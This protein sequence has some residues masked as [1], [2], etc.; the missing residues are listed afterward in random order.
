MDLN[1]T[2][3]AGRLADKPTLRVFDS[4]A[5]HVRCLITVKTEGPGERRRID[6]IPVVLWDPDSSEVAEWEA[7]Q[8]VWVA[9]SIQRRFWTEG[10]HGR[11][12]RVEIV[13]HE[14]QVSQEE[15]SVG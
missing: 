7:G 11:H 4:G 5:T 15:V 9:G 8:R 12:S 13:A 3:I 10:E 14:I 6:V 1:L 2:V